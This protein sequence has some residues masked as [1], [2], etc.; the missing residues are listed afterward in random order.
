MKTDITRE[1]YEAMDVDTKLNIL[2]DFAICSCNDAEKALETSENL[3]MALRKK[4]KIDTGIAG[5]MG[6]VGGLVGFLTQKMFFRG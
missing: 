6:F 4:V 1:T 3:K 2:F 5:M